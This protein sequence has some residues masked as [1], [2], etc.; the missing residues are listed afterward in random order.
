MRICGMKMVRCNMQILDKFNTLKKKKKQKE[1]DFFVFNSKSRNQF[2][3]ISVEN[4]LFIEFISEVWLNSEMLAN[5][6]FSGGNIKVFFN[7]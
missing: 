5:W 3:V 1:T 7:Y 4:L 2:L 6:D